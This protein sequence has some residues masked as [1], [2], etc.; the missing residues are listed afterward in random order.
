MLG[1]HV[2]VGRPPG[3]GKEKVRRKNETHNAKAMRSLEA[4]MRGDAAEGGVV[5][6][7]ELGLV[8]F[9]ALAEPEEGKGLDSHVEKFMNKVVVLAEDG[10]KSTSEFGE[11][12]EARELSELSKIDAVEGGERRRVC[13]G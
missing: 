13:K 2:L 7:R 1:D 8:A 12:G 6:A 5:G 9:L 11:G 10:V 3:Q 4:E